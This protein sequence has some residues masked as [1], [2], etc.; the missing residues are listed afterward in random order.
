MHSTQ[1]QV[2]LTLDGQR[3]RLAG[4]LKLA[5]RPGT[6]TVLT[7]HC[8]DCGAPF[9]QL[10]SGRTLANAE[11]VRRCE[12]HRK[13]ARGARVTSLHAA[14]LGTPPAIE[15]GDLCRPSAAAEVDADL[16]VVVVNGKSGA[17]TARAILDLA[18]G[19]KL[20]S[21]RAMATTLG[22]SKSG[23]MSSYDKMVTMGLLAKEPG[24]NG[25]YLITEA[26][27]AVLASPAGG[28]HAQ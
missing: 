5:D 3:F 6:H 23:V 10:A 1:R 20:P 7:A 9:A 2:E 16:Y 21:I 27:R 8:A 19:D 18:A 28:S 26:G 13:H 11:P 25:G 4:T 22:I 24:Y 12:T 14:A 17:V 15:V